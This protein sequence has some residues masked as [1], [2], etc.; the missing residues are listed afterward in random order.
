MSMSATA[1]P[2]YLAGTWKISP[3]NSDLSFAVRHLG[4]TTVHGRFNKLTGTIVTGDTVA[5]SWVNVTI[6]ANSV[7]TGF[8]A[9]D[10]YLKGDEVLAVSEHEELRFTSTGVRIA[11]G[12]FFVDGD[13]LI[14]GVTRP[15]TTLT[16]EVGGFGDDPVEHRPVLGLSA[17]AILRRADF[18]FSRNVPALIVSEEIAVRVDVLAIRNP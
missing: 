13:L 18:G 8:P 2:G 9:R 7:D 10:T 11:S 17:T 3:V 16:A 15:V 4:V 6:A 14:R 12:E 5:Q 1:L